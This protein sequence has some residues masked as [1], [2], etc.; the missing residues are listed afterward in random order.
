MSVPP[1]RVVP[2]SPGQLAA[3]REAPYVVFLRL[4]DADAAKV[5]AATNRYREFG[6]RPLI[7]DDGDAG[8]VRLTGAAGAVRDYARILKAVGHP[9]GELLQ[10]ALVPPRAWRL[11]TRSLPL[12]R[13]HVMAIL[14]LTGDSFSGDGVGRD[15]RV[16][17]ERAGDMRAW[18]AAIIDVGAESAR[19]DRPV[20]DEADEAELVGRTV[21]A[22]VREGHVVSSDT[23]KPAVAR[24][25]LDAGAEIVNDISGL[26]LGTG[27]A[28]AAA[29]ADAAYVLNYSFSVPK[30]RPEMPPR[31]ADVVAATVAW[32]FERTEQL[33]ACGLPRD[34]V[35]ID[36]GIAFGKSHDEDIQVQRRLG[37][38]GS[39][40]LP[41]LLAHSRKNFIGSVNGLPPGTRDL[42]THI[43]SA[44]AY[45]QGARIFRV[46]DV[47]GARRALELAAALTTAPAGTFA[48][49][50]ESWPWRAGAAASHMTVAAPDKPAP[51]GQRW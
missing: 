41:V 30:R 38:L 33:W 39:L 16:A 9:A 28:E 13:P 11:R 5:G 2:P 34:Q 7:V 21:A 12:D 24:A 3:D 31:Y 35:A 26:T 8:F 27:A 48:P 15:L 45:A 50:G 32:M 44:L 18:G 46:H 37:E 25:A 20:L 14:N 19:A 47:V 40:G 49:D 51:G 1:V 23:Y 22:L 17:I 36:P 43:A 42:E 6:E 10:R 29:E 4:G